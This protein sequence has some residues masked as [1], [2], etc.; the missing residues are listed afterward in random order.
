[1]KTSFKLLA[2]ALFVSLTVAVSSPGLAGDDKKQAKA[3]F[4]VAMFPAA[5][6]SKLWLCLEKYQAENKVNLTMI[7]ENGQILFEET[8]CGKNSKQSAVRQQFDMSQLSDGK[9]TFR[10]SAG[11]Q[12]EE[13]SFKLSTPTLEATQPTRLIAIK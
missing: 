4:T 8:L 3:A 2:C 9:Y 11:S 1:M 6:A 13:I 12:K 5:D 10:I 7:N